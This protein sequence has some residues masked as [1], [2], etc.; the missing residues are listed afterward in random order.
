MDSKQGRRTVT[1]KTIT[2]DVL[3]IGGGGAGFRAAIGAREKGAKTL[4]I[5]KG[6]LGRC[7]ATPMAGA[8]FTLDGLSMSRIEGLTGDPNDS[9]EKVFN[10]IV[11]QGCFLNNQTLVQQYVE[12]APQCLQ[13]LIDWGIKIKLSDE[14]MIFTTGT[15]I[16]DALV[17][18]ARAVE[19]DLLDDTAV[20]DLIVRDGKIAGALGLD[21]RTGEFILLKAK[22]VIIATGGWHKAFWPNTGMRDLSGEGIA[23][24]F[25][26][27]AALGNL[28]FITFC[29]NV[30]YDPPIW[31]GSLAPYLIT[32]MLGGRMTNSQGEE[33]L[34]Q[35]DPFMVQTGTFTEWNKCFLSHASVKEVRNGKGLPN[36]GVA[37]SR[38]NIPWENIEMIASIVFPKWKY[39]A[40]DLSE[41][42]RKLKDDEPVEVGPAVEYFEGGIIVN[43]RFETSVPGL[44]A[45]GECTLGAFGA[46]RVFAAITEML[47]HGADAG[48]NA[49][50]Y[51]MSSTLLEPDQ[52]QVDSL[53]DRAV[54]PL[55]KTDGPRPAQVRRRVQEAAHQMLGPIRNQTELESFLDLLKQT[56]QDDLPNLAP[57]S[58]SRV[59]NKD[60][61]DAIELAN[62]VQLLE[63]AASSALARTESRGVHYRE[64]H[65]HTDNDQWLKESV[66]QKSNGGFELSHRPL[67]VTSMMPPTGKTPYLQFVKQMMESRSDTGG[68]H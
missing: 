35:Y 10:D 5:S 44:Y 59:Y 42:G 52:R 7:G 20:L 28:E 36:G 1:Q 22:S 31:R 45:A 41:W 27:G 3:V 12:R 11:T 65:P 2:T 23:M 26:A 25:R 50:D 4:L 19:V 51:A 8:D 60:W 53:V 57:A 68:K 18:K 21:I 34:S 30:F 6:P 56:R 66:I 40:I 67:T 39:K 54:A 62:M 64:D 61:L 16:M 58:T 38:G 17:K 43:D 33:F 46:N 55:K 48:T 24:A 14:R 49:G 37:Y 63:M 29:C 9:P 47:V 15:G 32:L 13:E